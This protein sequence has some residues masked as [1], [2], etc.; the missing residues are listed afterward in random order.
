M[1]NNQKHSV[2]TRKRFVWATRNSYGPMVPTGL[3][4]RSANGRWDPAMGAGVRQ[5]KQGSFG[6]SVVGRHDNITLKLNLGDSLR[7][8]HAMQPRLDYGKCKAWILGR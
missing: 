7:R 3:T 1:F 4:L 6:M 2:L 5:W 8:L